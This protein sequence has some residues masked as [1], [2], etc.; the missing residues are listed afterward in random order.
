MKRIL[1]FIAIMA[2]AMVAGAAEKACIDLG[3]DPFGNRDAMPALIALVGAEEAKVFAELMAT[4]SG[5]EVTI[6]PDM[7]FD[8]EFGNYKL[9]KDVCVNGNERA[10]AFVSPKTGKVVLFPWKCLNPSLLVSHRAEVVAQVAPPAQVAPVVA[11]VSATVAPAPVETAPPAS[12]SAFDPPR[13][14]EIEA[15]A[16]IGAWTNSLAKGDWAYAEALLWN[17]VG[18]GKSVGAGF[19]GNYGSGESR[20][21]DYSWKEHALGVQVG[22]KGSYKDDDGKPANWQA[23]LRLLQERI[24]GGSPTS[25]YAM[26]QENMKVGLYLEN[27]KR[28]NAECIEGWSIEG[29]KSFDAS[30]KSTWA[31]DTLQKRDQAQANYV[32]ECRIDKLWRWRLSTG[33]SWTG[34]DHQTWAALGVELKYDF[35]NKVVLAFGPNLKVPLGVSS[36]YAGRSVAD[37]AT[38]GFGIRLEYG[39]K[40][41][42]DDEN[43]RVGEIVEID[44]TTGAPITAVPATPVAGTAP[45]VGS[46]VAV[47]VAPATQAV[48]KGSDPCFTCDNR[49]G[50]WQPLE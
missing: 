18:G 48:S 24:H 9:Q 32:R 2:Y 20:L 10:T 22:V 17:E 4:T 1:L 47:P 35:S 40:W 23:K 42:Y 39:D 13:R 12:V 28:I 11:P 38:L 43:R 19:Y 21:S 3:R 14:I 33:L 31:G 37:M 8:M 15:G 30:I 41:R 50:S 46:P 25:G 29:W 34:W 45:A 44:P 6:T 49:P 7:R 27:M 36:V 5:E 16:G 26:S